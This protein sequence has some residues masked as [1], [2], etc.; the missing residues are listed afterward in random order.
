[1]SDPRTSGPV[2]GPVAR[3]YGEPP[4]PDYAAIEPGAPG[5]VRLGTDDARWGRRVAAYLI[6]FAPE[7]V[8]SVPL[9]IAYVLALIDLARGPVGSALIWAGIGAV[10]MLAA[11]GWTIYNRWLI[12]GRTGQSLGK[13]VLRLHLVG[14][15]TVE[16]IGPLNAFVRDLVHILDRVTVGGFLWPLWHD[17]RKTFADMIMQTV[18]IDDRVP[19]R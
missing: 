10:L 1:M 4:A 5:P 18:V 17:K 13:R 14:E 11:L 8:A 6:D 12:G 7:I 3:R 16:P 2:Y 19:T 15:Q 9:A